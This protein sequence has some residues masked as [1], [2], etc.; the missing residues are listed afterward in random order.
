METVDAIKWVKDNQLYAL[1]EHCSTILKR[2]FSPCLNVQNEKVLII[3]DVGLDGRRLSPVL[4][5]GYYLA[6]KEMRY[7]AKL[8]LQGVKAKGDEA[9]P[10]VTQ[11][12]TDLREGVVI[13]SMSDK[14]GSIGD[15]GKSFRKFIKKNNHRFVSAMGLGDLRTEDTQYFL[16]AIDVPYKP[17]R[18]QHDL[19]KSHFDRAKE[20]RVTTP[21]GTDL[22]YNVDG[23]DGISA[24]GNYAMPGSG[25]NLPAGEVYCAPNGS[26]VEGKVVIDGSARTHERTILIKEPITLTIGKGNIAG[27]EGGK[28]AKEL[29]KTIEW[30]ASQAKNP[31][32]I[33]RICE[34]GIGLNPRAKIMGAMIVDDKTLGTAHIGIGSNY[35]FGGNIYA[36]IHLDQVFKNP[37]IYLDGELLKI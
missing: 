34:F 18:A 4:A 37:T 33:R 22:Y 10:F 12:L 32:S 24:D 2:V 19:L 30:A 7:D 27:I 11:S 15:L 5:A 29:E 9:D 31:G 25:G 35:W 20:I 26:K 23:I 3:G 36:I 13:L 1:S 17:M 6:A 16:S 28:E 14:M 21:A 8:I